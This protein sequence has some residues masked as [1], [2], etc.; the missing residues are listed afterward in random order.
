MPL[1]NQADFSDTRNPTSSTMNHLVT[2]ALLF[3][4]KNKGKRL[5]NRSNA[6]TQSSM[7]DLPLQT[8]KS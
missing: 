4:I 1:F 2:T 8:P 7:P 3:G 6:N 5:T